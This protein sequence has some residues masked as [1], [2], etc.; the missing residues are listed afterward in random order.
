MGNIL[1]DILSSLRIPRI[2]FSTSEFLTGSSA[3]N[4]RELPWTEFVGVL[5]K[6]DDWI[7][8]LNP[9]REELGY[10]IIVTDSVRIGIGT[11]QHLF[12][13]SKGACDVR[14]PRGKNYA[15]RL[16][17]LAD[18]LAECDD[19]NRICFYPPG[20][21]FPSAGFHIDRKLAGKHY[22]ISNRDKAV[23]H[24][25]SHADFRNE[26]SETMKITGTQNEKTYAERQN[27]R[28]YPAERI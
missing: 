21:L 4:I 20:E 11:S 22:Y 28:I 13:Y 5:D 18:K 26:I 16:I 6:I 10:P 15:I 19:I 27:Q 14:V 25:V 3:D 9:L 24:N 7:R 23:W 17:A 8:I 12:Q 2:W 1:Q